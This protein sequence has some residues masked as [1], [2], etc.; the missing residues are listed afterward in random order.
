MEAPREKGHGKRSWLKVEVK[1]HSININV[2]DLRI[3]VSN[4]CIVSLTV[5]K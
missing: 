3:C 1:K 4:I 5:C 2:H